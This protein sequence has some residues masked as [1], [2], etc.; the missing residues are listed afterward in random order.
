MTALLA[1]YRDA[2]ETSLSDLERA[3]ADLEALSDNH[4]DLILRL[5]QDPRY[6]PEGR[7]QLETSSRTET[8]LA[9]TARATAARNELGYVE[10]RIAEL[11]PPEIAPDVAGEMRVAAAWARIRPM[12]EAGQSPLE[13]IAAA[14]G[15][16]TDLRA[17]RRELPAWLAAAHRTASAG[18]GLQDLAGRDAAG[19]TED[20]ALGRIEELE[21]ELAGADA[22]GLLSYRRRAAAGRVNLEAAAGMTLTEVETGTRGPRLAAAIS[23]RYA[24]ASAGVAG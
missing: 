10:R 19:I 18:R 22:V 6:T 12:L 3:P 15:N 1:T 13:A 20:M 16:A 5:R 23:A 8:S 11:T 9:L 24:R 17:L 2:I 14:T 21:A 4:L 7:Q